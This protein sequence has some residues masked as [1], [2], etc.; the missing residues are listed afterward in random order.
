MQTSSFAE[1]RRRIPSCPSS[2]P[3]LPSSRLNLASLPLLPFCSAANPTAGSSSNAR[4]LPSFDTMTIAPCSST[5]PA[6]NMVK[7]VF[8]QDVQPQDEKEL[9]SEN[10]VVTLARAVIDP[11]LAYSQPLVANKGLEFREEESMESLNRHTLAYSQKRH[12]PMGVEVRDVE[13]GKVDSGDVKVAA[14][15]DG[16][17]RTRTRAG[18]IDDF[19]AL[20]EVKKRLHILG[21]EAHVSDEDPTQIAYEAI[22]TQKHQN[23]DKESSTSSRSTFRSLRQEIVDT[24]KVPLEV[25]ITRWFNIEKED[26]RGI[27]DNLKHLIALKQD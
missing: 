4:P 20:F 8:Y 16:G 11:I 13:T 9:Q 2:L 12:R 22:V 23:K 6:F 1:S 27:V 21:G 24:P 15:D 10:H 19:V 17:I 7:E 26:G 3:P 25:S 5:V 14:I 18:E